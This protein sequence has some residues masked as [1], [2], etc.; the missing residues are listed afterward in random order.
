MNVAIVAIMPT[1]SA[2]IRGLFF[3]TDP[4]YEFE[5]QKFVKNAEVIISSEPLTKTSSKLIKKLDLKQIIFD[6]CEFNVDDFWNLQDS[7]EYIP[8]HRFSQKK[9]HY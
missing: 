3:I 5:A 4:R 2:M 6:P 7:C 8:K 1:L 9:T